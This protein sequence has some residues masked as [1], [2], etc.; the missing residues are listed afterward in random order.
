MQAKNIVSGYAYSNQLPMTTITLP[1]KSWRIISWLTNI[2]LPLKYA[3]YDCI[4][5]RYSKDDPFIALTI[6][7][8][9]HQNLVE[10]L[11]QFVKGDLLEGAN[12]YHCDKCNKKVAMP[13]FMYLPD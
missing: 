5:F 4:L 10:S 8:R 11:D 13:L 9:N 1:E 12:A 3:K 6:D 7:I 2:H